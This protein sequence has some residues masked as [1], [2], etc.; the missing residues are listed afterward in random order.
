MV[1]KE[2]MGHAIALNSII[3]N[4]SRILGP[5]AA[6]LI[7]KVA[8]EKWCFFLNGLSYLA[9]LYSLTQ[10]KCHTE[11][12]TTGKLRIIEETSEAIRYL[13]NNQFILVSILIT[14]LTSIIFPVAIVLMPVFAKSILHGDSSTFAWL[15]ATLGIGA[16]FGVLMLRDSAMDKNF[17]S[18]VMRH[19]AI[20]GLCCLI[21]GL[22]RATWLSITMVFAIG[23]FQM[24]IFPKL[25]TGIQL[26]MDDRIRGRIMAIYN[27]TYLGAMPIGALLAGTSSDLIGPQ[28]TM[29]G[30]GALCILAFAIWI[31]ITNKQ[32][33]LL[34]YFK[35]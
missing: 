27:M 2:E 12:R 24:T 10:I 11:L 19:I 34:Q 9:T 15:T 32:V 14:A 23:Y 22:S 35:I 16:I 4:A 17:H 7:L 3:L 6:G 33:S 21:F 13:R 5:A 20:L 18:R 8:G 30:T 1:G 25:N 28:A 31:G 26:V 29:T